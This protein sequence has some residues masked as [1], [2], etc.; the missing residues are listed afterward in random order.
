M[1]PRGS[2]P[3]RERLERMARMYNSVGGIAAALHASKNSVLR[4]LKEEGL[5]PPGAYWEK[6]RDPRKPTKKA[7][8]E[9]TR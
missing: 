3:P 1:N 8:H 7:V 6:S 2:K 5:K 4:W 9:E